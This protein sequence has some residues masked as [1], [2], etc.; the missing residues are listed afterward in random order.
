MTTNYFKIGEVAEILE[1]TVRAIR[2]YEEQGLLSAHR[3]DGGTR[4][5]SEQHIDRLK[6]IM[7]LADN[8]F[9][10]EVIGLIGN[11]R[12]TCKTGDEGSKKISGIIDSAITDIEENV[13]DLKTLK[14]ELQAAKKLVKKCNG[15]TNAPSSV[16]CPDCPVNKN[17]KKIEVLNLVWE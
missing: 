7:H 1:T 16:E 6:A 2:Y 5:Y 11:T 8:G 12:E 17:L 13:S 15:C 14:A 4:L 10:L 3:T 9:S